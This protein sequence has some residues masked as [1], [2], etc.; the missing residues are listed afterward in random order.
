MSTAVPTAT[1]TANPTTTAAAG[2]PSSASPGR[3][4]ATLTTPAEGR[5]GAGARVVGLHPAR[6]H[7]PPITLCTSQSRSQECADSL[8]MTKTMGTRR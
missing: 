3:A 6:D 8:A 7:L 5:I 2:R 1:A 4:L